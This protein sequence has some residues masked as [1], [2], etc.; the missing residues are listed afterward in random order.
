M[1]NLVIL[2]S[3]LGIGLS[4]PRP[5]AWPGARRLPVGSPKGRLS[6]PGP[7]LEPGPE[8]SPLG[9]GGPW[10]LGRRGGYPCI[11]GGPCCCLCICITACIRLHASRSQYALP[12]TSKYPSRRTSPQSPHR[13]QPGWYFFA[14]SSSRYCPSIPL[15]QL[16][17]RLPLSLW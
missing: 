9:G 13:K 15:L 3:I 4:P 12:S 5:R 8:G 10:A 7:N 6:G 2:F 16:P 1:P 14:D 17:H 11:F